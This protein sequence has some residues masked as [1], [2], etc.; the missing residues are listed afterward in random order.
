M[1]NDG[2]PY[3]EERERQITHIVESFS[4]I[5][6]SADGRTLAKRQRWQLEDMIRHALK[7]IAER[8]ERKALDEG[9]EIGRLK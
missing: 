4:L 6:E 8:T 7:E 3:Y 1:T 9:I 5:V 2:F